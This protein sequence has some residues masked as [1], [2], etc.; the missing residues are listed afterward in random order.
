ME[1]IGSLL[2]DA[3]TLMVTGMAVVYLFLTVLV[4]LVQLMSKLVSEEQPEPATQPLASKTTIPTATGVNPKLIAAISSAV[5]QYR[6]SSA[7]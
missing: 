7:K 3:A 2:A 5:H 4:Y 1:N 6:N